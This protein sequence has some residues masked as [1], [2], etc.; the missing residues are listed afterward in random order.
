MGYAN[1][2][3][4][5]QFKSVPI[6]KLK[7]DRSFVCSLPQD[8]TMVRIVAAIASIIKIEVIAEG[9]ETSGQRDWL[10]ARGIHIGQGYLY[11]EALPVAIFTE[12]YLAG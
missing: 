6:S 3:W 10:L 5:S 7:M 11:S 12:R 2:N 1:L 9:V 8:D 4:L